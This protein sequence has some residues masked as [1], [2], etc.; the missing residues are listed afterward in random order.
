MSDG[1]NVRLEVDCS[2]SVTIGIEEDSAIVT[3][4]QLERVVA[5]HIRRM[6]TDSDDARFIDRIRL[7]GIR[8]GNDA[9]LISESVMHDLRS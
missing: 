2:F 4:M 1:I 7:A 8:D 3:M 5:Q 6:I 9:E